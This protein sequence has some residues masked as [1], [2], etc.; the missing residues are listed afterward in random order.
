M[1]HSDAFIEPELRSL[2]AENARA[3][4]GTL[5]ENFEFLY[6]KW[7]ILMHSP[8]IFLMS[9]RPMSHVEFKKW[10]MSH[11]TYM[12]MSHV[13]FKKWPCHRVG[14]K[15]WPCRHV[16]FRGLGPSY[17]LGPQQ[18]S[19]QATVDNMI[20]WAGQNYSVI[21]CCPCYI[22]LPLKLSFNRQGNMTTYLRIY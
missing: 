20:T 7:C 19:R 9:L 21:L 2:H 5:E 11:V 1:V 17:R 16:E 12:A 22:M 6:L 8:I 10:P 14:F 4:G 18:P 15:I 13:D 3:F